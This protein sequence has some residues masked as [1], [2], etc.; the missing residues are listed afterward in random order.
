[1]KKLPARFLPAC[2]IAADASPE[3]VE[4]LDFERLCDEAK[5]PC[6][7]TGRIGPRIVLIRDARFLLLEDAYGIPVTPRSE[8]GR[9]RALRILEALAHVFHD[10]AAREC[11]CGRGLFG[12]PTV[13]GRPPKS[14]QALSAAERMRAYRAR[15]KV[16]QDLRRA[17][18]ASMI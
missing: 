8:K 10:Y 7:V 12:P 6:R 13:L 9:I 4:V 15:R 3:I 5:I 2:E 14:G 1:M 18:S 11:V 16:A 17:P